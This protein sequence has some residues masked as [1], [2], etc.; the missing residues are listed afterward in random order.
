MKL[1]GYI[2]FDRWLPAADTML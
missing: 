2:L 1:L